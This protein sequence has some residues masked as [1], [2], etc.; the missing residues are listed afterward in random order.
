MWAQKRLAL[1]T[2][3]KGKRSQLNNFRI[4]SKKVNKTAFIKIRVTSQEK[5]DWQKKAELV[6]GGNLAQLLRS[7][8]AGQSLGQLQ[9]R[10]ETFVAAHAICK[11]IN[12]I[13]NNVNQLTAQVNASRTVMQ[14][15]LVQFLQSSTVL[16]GKYQQ[17]IDLFLKLRK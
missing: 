11:E 3:A 2:R 16:Q 6:T 14:Q 9:E 7:A 10:K 8:V 5:E 4:N 12:A 1:A 13:G 15:D 17:L